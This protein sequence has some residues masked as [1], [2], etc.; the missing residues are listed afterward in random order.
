MMHFFPDEILWQPTHKHLD[1]ETRQSAIG[2]ANV[3]GAY[4][5]ST[6]A[7]GTVYSNVT[8]DFE[9][10]FGEI[11]DSLTIAEVMDIESTAFCY[12]YA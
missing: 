10:V 12:T 6:A 3:T 2:G 9:L 8:L 11:A 4:P 5:F 1:W 7:A